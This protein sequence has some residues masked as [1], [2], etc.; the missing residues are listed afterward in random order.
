[1]SEVTVSSNDFT[2]AAQDGAIE[3]QVTHTP[4]E[5]HRVEIEE[6]WPEGMN[7]WDVRAAITEEHDEG[8]GFE[9]QDY[10]RRFW[11]G[12]VAPTNSVA[13]F[14]S[15]LRF[16]G[17]IRG[18]GYIAQTES[19]SEDGQIVTTETFVYPSAE[20]VNSFVTEA[21][22]DRQDERLTLV[23]YQGGHYTA[24]EFI[25]AFVEKGH[26]LMASDM[27]HQMHDLGDHA[28]GWVGMDPAL[29]AHMREILS[30]YVARTDA[31]KALPLPEHEKGFDDKEVKDFFVPSSL[32]LTA[33]S[34][35]MDIFSDELSTFVFFD[36]IA[37]FE[38]PSN[39]DKTAIVERMMKRKLL[40]TGAYFAQLRGSR[41]P[42]L[43]LADLSSFSLR[44]S[45]VVTLDRYQRAHEA[46]LE[47]AA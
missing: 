44:D 10:N 14:A 9:E 26:I 38:Y 5:M 47:M 6:H 8:W 27:P 36:E 22:G 12:N 37:Q 13:N 34:H 20:R 31:E 41:P 43:T 18:L 32:I 17:V 21:L 23:E 42:D 19:H 29:A 30:H 28:L 39:M 11:L 1:M 33:A 45:A 2:I 46:G 25:R 15:P 24:E 3:I 35:N 40:D 16:E 4:G 7:Q